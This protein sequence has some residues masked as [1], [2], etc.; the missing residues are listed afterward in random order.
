VKHTVSVTERYNLEGYEFAEVTATV[1]FTDED[2]DGNP[3]RF[4]LEQT[5]SL[6]RSHRRRYRSLV[7]EEGKSFL[8]D[9][10]ALES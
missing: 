10:P 3:S 4:G 5:D 9:H 1:E 6:L 8:L 7:P 2:A